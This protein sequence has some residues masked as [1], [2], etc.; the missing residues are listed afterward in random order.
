MVA[1]FG[2]AKILDEPPDSNPTLTGEPLG[3]LAYMAPEQVRGD[4]S[5]IS[6]ATDVYGLGAILYELL[7]RRRP[8]A[9]LTRAERLERGRDQRVE[10]PRRA[11]KLIPVDLETICLKCLEP[12][13]A[14]RYQAASEV[15]NELRRYLGGL[16]ILARRPSLREQTTRWCR[17]RRVTATLIALVPFLILA[18]LGAFVASNAWM[19]RQH[20]ELLKEREHAAQLSYDSQVRLASSAYQE[21][22]LGRAQ[23]ILRD[24]MPAN[25]QPD[26]RE[27]AWRYLWNESRR[28]AILLGELPEGGL[29]AA[30]TASAKLLIVSSQQGDVTAFDRPRA[31]RLWTAPPRQPGSV[32]ALALS[33]NAQLLAV[34]SVARNVRNSS[35]EDSFVELRDARAGKSLGSPVSLPG[36]VVEKVAFIENGKTLAVLDHPPG[37]NASSHVSIWSINT[38]SDSAKPV[39]TPLQH[40]ND[41]GPAAFSPTEARFASTRA[42]GPLCL[43]DT[44]TGACLQSLSQA[45]A[46]LVRPPVFSPDGQRLAVYDDDTSRI[47]V[48]QGDTGLLT[49]SLGGFTSTIERLA[50]QPGGQSL[51]ATGTDGSV[52]LLDPPHDRRIVLF[53]APSDPVNE[54]TQRISFTS[55]G[56]GVVLNRSA[57]QEPDLVELRSAERR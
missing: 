22:Q 34:G 20:A 40:F 57:Y 2:L 47:L 16:P 8:H 29:A 33:P 48:W 53:P 21:D 11:Q 54:N 5:A 25:G 6:P 27:F 41:L 37:A 31:Q 45:P 55:D 1:D 4:L 49:A 24:V 14:D 7:T 10:P 17:R 56:R 42:G 19:R 18:A 36:R 12:E 35:T 23:R 38:G 52:V 50:L 39:L 46:S 43:F 15:A 32:R 13:P 3:T 44:L 9:G 26:R 51:V 30:S 28:H